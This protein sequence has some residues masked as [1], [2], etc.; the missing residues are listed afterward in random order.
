MAAAA[1]VD[2]PTVV[3]P[4]VSAAVFAPGDTA[5]GDTARGDAV[6]GRGTAR[7]TE[8]AGSGTGSAPGRAGLLR[9]AVLTA[10]STSVLPLTALATGP[11][12]A[13]VLGPHDRGLMSAVLAPMFVAMFVAAFAI[14]EA[15][16]YAVAKLKVP[17]K[18]AFLAGAPLLLASGLVSTAVLWVTAPG[19]M[20]GTPEAVPLLRSVLPC[21]PLMMFTLL[22]R[23]AM[24]GSGHY[25]GVAVE[26]TTAALGRAAL[27]IGFAVTGLLTAYTAIWINLA[28]TIA[29]AL[30][31]TVPLVRSRSEHRGS[32]LVLSFRALSAQMTVYALRGWGGVCANLVNWRLDQAIM[33]ALIGATP[34]G[35]Y[36]VA[37]SLA[38]LPSTLIGATKSVIFTEA[39]ARDDL[40]LAARA[41]RVVLVAGLLIDGVLALAAPLLVRL[42]FGRAFEPSAPLAQ[43]LLIGNIPFTAE[44]ILASGL[45]AAGRPGLRSIGQV[46]AA[47]LT[48][49]GIFV[50]VPVL[51]PS[52]AAYT[53]VVAYTLSFAMTITFFCRST[54]IPVRDC[55]VIRRSDLTWL[56]GVVARRRARQPL[57]RSG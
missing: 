31:L 18:R 41:A 17:P 20:G 19:L 33:P 51:G 6:P 32:D 12:L 4:A 16:T 13:R 3:L 56:I 11:I 48:V 37:V 1:S 10:A 38:E 53:S 28:S 29:A 34:L 54:G 42:L 5:R 36:A 47:V 43:V 50:L 57:V 25:A 24:S 15:S 22:Q 49:A 40:R 39:S 27:L 30:V 35:Y 9:G 21:L 52:G 23:F 8:P 45:L 14:P 7:R 44:V 46:I 26:R 2:M 55:V